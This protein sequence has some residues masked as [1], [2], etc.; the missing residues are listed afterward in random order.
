MKLKVELHFTPLLYKIILEYEMCLFTNQAEMI[1][2]QRDI[3]QILV[4][5]T[6]VTCVWLQKHTSTNFLPKV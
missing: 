4:N 1:I 3:S 5:T 6:I 2:S